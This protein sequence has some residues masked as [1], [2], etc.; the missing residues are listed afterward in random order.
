[1][2]YYVIAKELLWIKP[3]EEKWTQAPLGRKRRRGGLYI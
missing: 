3:T 2:G 1:M